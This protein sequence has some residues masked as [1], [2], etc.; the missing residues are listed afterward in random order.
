MRLDENAGQDG[1]R[2]TRTSNINGVEKPI[3]PEGAAA[4][5][6]VPV[7]FTDATVET[8]YALCTSVDE[9]CGVHRLDL[10]TAID[11]GATVLA[12]LDQAAPPAG[13]SKE[14]IDAPGSSWRSQA[15]TGRGRAAGLSVLGGRVDLVSRSRD[16][17]TS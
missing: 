1:R 10:A 12:L 11:A 14:R 13:P 6:T 8:W 4:L 17:G 9:W 5:S 3:T 16:R 7:N 15:R 2:V